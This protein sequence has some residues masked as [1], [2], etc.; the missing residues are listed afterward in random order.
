MDVNDIANLGRMLAQF[1]ACF[2]DCFARP[3]GRELLKVYVRGLLSGVQRKNTEA[4]A[5]EQGVAPRTLQ[6]FLESI[7]WDE[8]KL[9][10]GCQEMVANEHA[11][12][13]AIGC[14]DET[15][16]AKSGRHTAGVKRQ[17][18]GNRGKIENC[19][20]HVALAYSSPGFDCLLDARLYLPK[21]WANDPVRRKKTTF[22]TTLSSRPS[23]RSRWI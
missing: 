15:G 20:N 18:N 11:S 13:E 6:R 14:I 8:G 19:V 21:E 9:R 22:P 5:L 2:A 4:I 12:P 16:I 7:V 3:A 10:D 17:Y 1:L 23:R